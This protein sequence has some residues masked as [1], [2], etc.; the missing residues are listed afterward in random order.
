M[1]RMV[2]PISTGRSRGKPSPATRPSG[3]LDPSAAGASPRRKGR[4]MP[5]ASGL[6][7]TWAGARHM[8]RNTTNLQPDAL[9]ALLER[10]RV[11]E[12][13]PLA[14]LLAS[15]LPT[16]KA[17]LIALI[18]AY[19][20]D[21]ERLRQLWGALDTVQQAAVT[22]TLYTGHFDRARLRAKYG[23][24][25]DWGKSRYGELEKPS[26]LRF[27][28]Y[29][30]VVPRELRPLLEEF[31]PPPRPARAQTGDRPPAAVRQELYDYKRRERVAVLR[32]IDRGSIRANAATRRVTATGAE[33]IAE[34]LPA[35]IST[36]WT[37]RCAIGARR[38]LARSR[39]FPGR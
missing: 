17:E 32:L 3:A 20:R 18:S 26:T 22:E 2:A 30:G 16:R 38:S 15:Y 14:G 21:P 29:H 7:A 25:P 28:V 24:E 39:P 11:R 13:K 27:F 6:S 33:S 4:P 9:Q 5:M 36:R 34:I 31:V 12:L 8:T 1:R 10:Y 37:K 19:V 35:A 23:Q